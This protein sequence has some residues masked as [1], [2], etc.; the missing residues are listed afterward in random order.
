M[1]LAQHDVELPLV[2]VVALRELAVLIAVVREGG[3]VL[4]VCYVYSAPTYTRAGSNNDTH[5]PRS[6]R[7]QGGAFLPLDST[8]RSQIETDPQV[9]PRRE[10]H[11]ADR[12]RVEL[13]HLLV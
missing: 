9:Q 10:R 7:T 1:L 2:L 5:R 11:A 6:S 8:Y 12:V 13:E 4:P 3:V